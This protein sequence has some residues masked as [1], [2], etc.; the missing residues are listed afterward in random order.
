MKKKNLFFVIIFSTVVSIFNM[1]YYS[2]VVTK[3]KYYEENNLR[4]QVVG[5]CKKVYICPENI[6]NNQ[7][8]VVKEA[9]EEYSNVRKNLG[10][11]DLTKKELNDEEKGS[12]NLNINSLSEDIEK[13]M[14]KNMLNDIYS[15][16]EEDSQEELNYNTK[17]QAQSVFKV[18]TGKI[19]ENLTTS[20]KV[21]LLYVSLQLGKENYKKV[22]EYL[23]A[24]DAEEGVL[25]ALKLLKDDLS[26][27]EY[28]KVRKIAGKFIDMDAAERL[29]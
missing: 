22:E 15:L 7:G 23:Y 3:A 14:D 5:E 20:D 17:K 18:S 19:Q 25:K 29:K 27:K 28:G 24:V 2:S 12:N 4:K 9:E 13:K 11:E 6:N 1:V 10:K 26:K 8:K 16:G 21:K